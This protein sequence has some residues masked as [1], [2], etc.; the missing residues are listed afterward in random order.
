[1]LNILLSLPIGGI[2]LVIGNWIGLLIFPLFLVF[3]SNKL[4]NTY[5]SRLAMG[6]SVGAVH[7]LLVVWGLH[8]YALSILYFAWV[9]LLSEPK[10]PHNSALMLYHDT[11]SGD[12]KKFRSTIRNL[13]ILRILGY[14][15]I[16]ILVVMLFS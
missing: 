12:D 15:S 2:G 7:G 3:S 10:L 1:M 16:K 8:Y 11:L 6:I 14:I 4:T 9:I 13:I 5:L